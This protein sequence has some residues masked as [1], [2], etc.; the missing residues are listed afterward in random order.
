MNLP[1]LMN[2]TIHCQAEPKHLLF[3][4]IFIN[5]R[6]I[7]ETEPV[8]FLITNTYA[9]KQFLFCLVLTLCFKTARCQSISQVTITPA[10]PTAGDTIFVITAITYSGACSYGLVY[11]YTTATGNTITLMPTYCG[12]GDSTA[13]TRTDT[14]KLAPLPAGNYV[15]Q[16]EYHQGSICPISNFDATLGQ[17]DTM[18]GIG[19][20]STL[21]TEQPGLNRLLKLYP[22]PA[23]E[24]ITVEIPGATPETK[25]F[26]KVK[27]LLGQLVMKQEVAGRATVL[28]IGHFPAGVYLLEVEQ[29][30]TPTA[31]QRLVVE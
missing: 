3:F 4:C 5:G 23:K 1:V 8:P 16:V 10:N 21:L 17:T 9:M 28:N 29:A 31:K 6:G 22:N 14:L 19:N 7:L 30:F 20:I 26:I 13:C 18:L 24:S 12:Y 27:N 11:T 2:G 15:L 25:G